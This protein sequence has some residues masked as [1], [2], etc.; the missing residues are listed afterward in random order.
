MAAI[1]LRH[2]SRAFGPITA[3]KDL[4]IQVADATLLC[5][6]GPSGSGK[7]T[8]MRMIAGLETPDRGEIRLGDRNITRL[9]PRDRRIGM[10][11]QGYA[12]YPHMS[13]RDNIAYPLRVR[14]TGRDE[15]NRRVQEVAAM[16]GIEHLLD[17]AVAQTSGG[18]QQR[19]AL[20][21]A[22]V[23]R[24]ELYLLDE[25]ISALD[26]VLRTTMRGEIKRLQRMLATTTIVVT[27]DQLDA[28]SMADVIAVLKDGDLQQLGTPEEVFERPANTFVARFLGEPQMNLLH[29]RLEA[30]GDHLTVTV[31]DQ[32]LEVTPA[33]AASLRA[34]GDRHVLVGIRPRAVRVHRTPA[35]GLM[36]AT[37]YVA[38]PEGSRVIYE[39]QLGEHLF[40]VEADPEL[41]LDMEDRVFLELRPET[42]HF[43][44][45]EDDIGRRIA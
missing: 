31:L 39:F 41:R 8:T 22:I 9:E 32:P 17:R 5:L 36:P 35:A 13:V 28:L 38:A 20:A 2:L 26:A 37:V 42:L 1:E 11:F 16:L 25:P 21:R 40:K 10:M 27:H 24:P 44:A 6:L 34:G 43:F 4:S 7:T 23:Q 18:Q 14:G 30:A 19:A 3:V 29:G 45:A 12:L 33:A 15:R